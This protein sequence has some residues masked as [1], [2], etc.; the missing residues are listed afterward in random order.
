VGRPNENLGVMPAGESHNGGRAASCGPAAVHH[1]DWTG[2]NVP[3]PL[4]GSPLV[5]H[6]PNG[7]GA[8][9]L[10]E[11]HLRGTAERARSFAADISQE[12][13]SLAYHA[14]LWHDLGKAHSTFQRYLLDQA[15]GVGKR[16][17]GGDH[18]GAGA[19]K[20]VPVCDWLP[21]LVV[22]HHGGLPAGSELK[23]KLH[24]WGQPESHV[25]EA[26]AAALAGLSPAVLASPGRLPLPLWVRSSH[27]TEFFVRML[28]SCL[29]DADCLDTE[30][31]FN[32]DKADRRGDSAMDLRPLWERYA[33]HQEALIVSARGTSPVNVVRERIYWRALE[34]ARESPGLFRLTVPTG[35]GKTLV[36]LGFALRHALEHGQRRVIFAVPYTSITEQTAAVYRGI[37]GADSGVVLEHHSAV[38]ARDSDEMP[39]ATELWR[40]LASEN[41][42]APVVVT[43]TVQLFESLLGRGTGACRKLH[44]VANSVVVLDE[45][46][47]LPPHLLTPLLDVL[48]E[49]VTNYRV[50][51]VICTATQPAF[52]AVPGF[53]GFAAGAREIAP[54]PPE[55]FEQLKRVRYTWPAEGEK[56]SWEEVAG[57]LRASPRAL[58]ILNTKRDAMAL[59]DALADPEA[60][61]LSTLLCGKHRQ[62]VLET[63]R[64][65]LADGLPCRL[66]AT[67][68]VEAGVD[69]N[70][71]LVLRA[72]GP[73]ASVVQAAG[74]CNREGRLPAKGEVVIFDPLEGGLPPGDY[75]KASQNAA[76]LLALLGREMDVDDPATVKRFF[77][78]FYGTVSSDRNGVQAVR[79]ALDYPETARLARLID[80]DGVSVVVPYRG[81]DG[82]DGTVDELLER[83]RRVRRGPHGARPLLRALQ[84]YIVAVRR[85]PAMSFEKEL[86]MQELSPG[87]GVY[88]WLG[89]YDG[90]VRGLRAESRLDPESLVI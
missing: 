64:A 9:H 52:E 7:S 18:K 81:L 80:D 49:L 56:M 43:T 77:Q 36:G 15:R 44:N 67:Q 3:D 31:H 12:A 45:A 19:T 29:V 73:L 2:M 70:F 57:R 16:R 35:G 86:L 58:A 14:G 53:S 23:G 84:P 47:S 39:D 37:F 89:A 69:L 34:V 71:P 50:S 22:G 30:A 20:I 48:R 26:L 6:T 68:V 40:R 13:A 61:H 21:F 42:D 88:E 66:V 76:A 74:R 24:E 27:E 78:A 59:L 85:R 83:V 25:H 1:V 33:A 75:R 32:P 51:V 28:F 46:Q 65:R 17:S 55:L 38:A 5:A 90:R 4:W 63:V 60:L 8:W 41:W 11:A 10:L 79:A 72:F 82:E 62:S 54:N 87:L